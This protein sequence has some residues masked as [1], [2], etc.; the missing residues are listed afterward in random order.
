MEHQA[1]RIRTALI[2]ACAT[3]FLTLSL[4]AQSA[5][6]P[7]AAEPPA[8]ATEEPAPAQAKSAAPP[9]SSMDDLVAAARES[10]AKR[11]ATTG[12][13]KKKVITNADVKKAGGRLIFISD[14]THGKQAEKKA[15]VDPRTLAQQNDAKFRDRKAVE[16]RLAA[17]TER[18]G[19]LKVQLVAAEQKYYE[20]NDPGFR[21][22]VLKERF[23]SARTQLDAARN[24]ES[25]IREE[26][27]KLDPQS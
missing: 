9:T 17:A 14:G 10:K 1:V 19:E 8:T 3:A 7:P 13:K 5:E 16:E 15:A 22:S 21:D 27:A 26:L 4:H 18:V 24:E 11:A 23:E 20:S 12:K 25:L 2:A 6:E